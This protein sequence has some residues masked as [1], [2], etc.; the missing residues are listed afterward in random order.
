MGD[1]EQFLKQIWETKPLHRPSTAGETFDDLLSLDDLDILL[2][3]SSLRWPHVE[4]VKDGKRME[5]SDFTSGQP[6]GSR[7]IPDVVVPSELFRHFHEGAT[8]IVNALHR[9][10]YPLSVFSR[11][12]A[13][14]LGVPAQVNAYLTPPTAQGFIPHRDP[15]D[16]FTLQIYGNKQWKIWDRDAL[17][18]SSPPTLEPLVAPGDVLYMPADFPHAAAT[19]FASSLHLTVGLKRP[20]WVDVFR[21]AVAVASEMSEFQEPLPARF[22]DNRD[23]LIAEVGRRLATF[24]KRIGEVD[25]ARLA[26][27]VTRDSLSVRPSL[28]RGQIEQSIALRELSEDSTVRQR[29]GATCVVL[30]A[31]DEEISVLLGDRELR[32]P[33]WVEPAIRYISGT[34]VFSVHELSPH[35]EDEESRQ[36]LVRRLVREGFLEIVL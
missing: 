29:A 24:G 1:P 3:S 4:L 11:Q 34:Q 21:E 20:L 27:A 23:E 35:M 5:P 9:F 7:L 12:L 33:A 6:F 17:E 22:A 36:V 10:W 26:D 32:M 31:G 13:N 19:Q 8:I 16:V 15:Y 18:S 25:P 2:T 30:P 28:M 14:D